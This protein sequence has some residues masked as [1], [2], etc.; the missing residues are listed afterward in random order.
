MI[1]EVGAVCLA[2]V[3]VVDRVCRSM[4]RKASLALGEKQC[5]T[6]LETARVSPRCMEAEVKLL[7]ARAKYEC[8][9]GGA[10]ERAYI[11]ASGQSEAFQERLRALSSSIGVK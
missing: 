11:Q 4:E 10:S 1:M 7:E 9:P 5:D 3:V 2:V 6:E 8:S